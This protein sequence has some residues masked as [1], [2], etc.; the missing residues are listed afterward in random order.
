[1]VGFHDTTF[2]S[3]IL[4]NTWPA[5]SG[6]N[7][8]THTDRHFFKHWCAFSRANKWTHAGRRIT[9]V[10]FSYLLGLHL[11]GFESVVGSLALRLCSLWCLQ[12]K[13]TWSQWVPAIAR[14]PPVDSEVIWWPLLLC[15]IK[16]LLN[17]FSSANDFDP[18]Y[19]LLCSWRLENISTRMVFLRIGE[20]EA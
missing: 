4:S 2:C 17:F 9:I 14:H 18:V 1:M 12:V 3:G 5:L 20:R 7:K 13:S 15:P 19:L 11:F 16:F 8:W 10:N 6:A